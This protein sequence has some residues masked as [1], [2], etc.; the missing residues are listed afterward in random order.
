LPGEP[1][2]LRALLVHWN[3][4]A[5]HVDHE[6]GDTAQRARARRDERAALRTAQALHDPTE[7]DLSNAGMVLIW[8]CLRSLFK[9]LGLMLD[10][11]FRDSP[12]QHRAVGLLT[13]LV[14]GELVPGEYQVPLA[15]VLCGLPLTEAFDFGQ[16]VSAR[17]ADECSNLLQA[18]IA[19][20]PMLGELSISGFRGSFL[21]RKGVLSQRDGAWLLRVERASY[22]VLLDR[23]PWSASLVKLPW[24]EAPLVAEW[25]RP[26]EDPSEPQVFTP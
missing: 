14:T 15:K 5:D 13:H 24:M 17:E 25:A 4:R 10:Q 19:H 6:R 18:A 16:E 3:H 23:L 9:R 11:K 21:L 2:D 8:P 7:I 20:T 26:S 12:C 1:D 22:D